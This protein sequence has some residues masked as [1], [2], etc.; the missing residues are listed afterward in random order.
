MDVN[1]LMRR[2]ID[3]LK[4]RFQLNRE[5]PE[6]QDKLSWELPRFFEMAARRGIIII[7]IDNR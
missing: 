5:M 1:S 3:E 7:V 2:M 6:S 4:T